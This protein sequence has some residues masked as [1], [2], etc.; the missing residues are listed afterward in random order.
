V[1]Q[2]STVLQTAHL[3][4]ASGGVTFSTVV[5]PG[6]T[7]LE[8]RNQRWGQGRQT[9]SLTWQGYLSELQPILDLF[10]EARGIAKSFKFTPPGY[11]TGD[12]RFDSDILSVA[13]QPSQ[14]GADLIASLTLNVI[15]V[16]DE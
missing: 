11:A 12:F 13:L 7:G 4:G 10:T 8:N 2:L 3:I 16:L 15:Q 6:S 1:A 9:W 14:K 5:F